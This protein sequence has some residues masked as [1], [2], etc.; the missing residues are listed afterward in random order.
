MAL[1]VCCLPMQ[2]AFAAD[3]KW[4]MENRLVAHALGAIGDK[5]ETNSKEAFLESWSQG[6]RALEAD[7]S[8]TSDGV[9]VLRHD[10]DQDS[11]YQLEQAV[12]GNIVM[13]AADYKNQKINFRYTPLTAVELFQLMNEYKD[14]YVITDTKNI[15]AQTVRAQFEA[16]KK[17]ADDLN[18]PEVL[19]RLVVQIY[20]EEM[21]QVVKE[22]YPFEN[23]IYTLY[24]TP[25]PDYHVIG[26]F[27]VQNGIDVVAMNE[28]IIRNGGVQILNQKGIKVY[29]HTVNRM[30]DMQSALGAGCYGV[31]TDYI[32]PKDL[33]QIGFAK[34]SKLS[35]V[36]VRSKEK[37]GF[38]TTCDIQGRQYVK[39][40]DI[41]TLLNGTTALFSAMYNTS[42]D[43]L[44]L[45]TGE[46]FV[47]LGNEMLLPDSNDEYIKK[48]SIALAV[49]GK[50]LEHTGYTIDGEYYY[51]LEVLGDAIGFTFY[52]SDVPNELQM[53]IDEP[54]TE[55]AKKQED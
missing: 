38:I 29:A 2:A 6:Y 22:V 19:D 20:N 40:R 41:G 13:S 48:S 8:M 24:Q 26:D 4:Y 17:Y 10:F 5:R 55:D 18:T 45:T 16:L 47:S 23:W 12:R 36:K 33:G 52:A 51:P 35:R 37:E 28:Q 32:K 14:V 9:L 46:D 50:R 43:V 7:F 21:Y 1:C 39:L 3:A 27:C 54:E 31:Y 44:Q 53:V 49:D 25:N 15:D 11:Y 42:T 34:E 30:L